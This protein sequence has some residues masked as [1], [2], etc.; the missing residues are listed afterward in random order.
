VQ[1]AIAAVKG[2]VQDTS[3]TEVAPDQGREE[4]EEDEEVE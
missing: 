1:E 3:G 2:D 4:D